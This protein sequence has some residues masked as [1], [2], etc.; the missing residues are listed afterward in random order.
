MASGQPLSVEGPLFKVPHVLL[1]PLAGLL[2]GYGAGCLV[3]AL[4]DRCYGG[5]RLL[6]RYMPGGGGVEALLR[7]TGTIGYLLASLSGGSR[8][9]LPARYLYTPLLGAGA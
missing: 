4:L 9:R 7:W 3:A 1:R 5:A 6:G 8:A 2:L